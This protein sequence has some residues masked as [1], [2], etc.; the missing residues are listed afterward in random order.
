MDFQFSKSL[1]SSQILI[2]YLIPVVLLSFAIKGM[3]DK[4]RIFSYSNANWGI[5][6]TMAI[7]TIYF[8]QGLSLYI[9]GISI[10][11]ICLFKINGGKKYLIGIVA[12]I[13]YFVFILPFLS[14]LG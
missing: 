2:N 1:L 10:L 12:T 9:T 6:I 13:I 14:G 8:L 7:L 5:A 4:L 11:A 3:L